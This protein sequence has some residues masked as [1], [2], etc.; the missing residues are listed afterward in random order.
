MSYLVDTNILIFLCK[1]KSKTLEE[2]FRS[3]RPED[4]L[5]SSVTIAELLYGVNKS[6]RKEQNLQAILKILSPFK[7]IDFDSRDAWTYGEIRADLERKG[8]PIGGN[9]LMI[10]AQAK[11]RNLI[12]ITNNTKEYHRVTGL[13]VQDWTK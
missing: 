7:V 11:R 6:Q 4:F 8:T 1:E 12:I 5:V 9:D 3:H 2:K 10:A 13:K